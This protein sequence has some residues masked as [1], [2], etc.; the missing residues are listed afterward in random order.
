MRRFSYTPGTSFSEEFLLHSSAHVWW[1][2]VFY[3]PDTSSSEVLLLYSSSYI[4]WGVS[5]TLLMLVLVRRFSYTPQ[6]MFGEEFCFYTPDASSSEE[7]LL[8]SSGYV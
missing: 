1:G 3:T 2:F 4:W 8:H 5:L 7:F 6:A